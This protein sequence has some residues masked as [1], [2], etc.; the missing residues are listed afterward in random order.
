MRSMSCRDRC[1]ATLSS[2]RGATAVED[3]VSSS[4]RCA[5]RRVS[6]WSPEREASVCSLSSSS[7][8]RHP[9]TFVGRRSSRES[10]RFLQSS[11]SRM[12]SSS[13]WSEGSEDT[14]CCRR[15]SKVSQ[16]AKF[17]WVSWRSSLHE[18]W[19]S[20]KWASSPCRAE[21]V[22]VERLSSFSRRWFWR[23]SADRTSK[24]ALSDWEHWRK[25]CCSRASRRSNIGSTSS[26]AFIWHSSRASWS[27]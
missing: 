1:A 21:D 12:R 7:C 17:S 25:D 8:S 3:C 14:A 27:R 10:V 18:L 20:S 2:A 5:V 15:L 13:A 16:R 9:S 22:A 23:F 6:R 4:K 19:V 24:A 26:I 11:K